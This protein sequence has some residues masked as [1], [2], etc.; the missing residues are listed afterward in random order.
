MVNYFASLDSD[1]EDY[2]PEVEVKKAAPA[3]DVSKT[4]TKSTKS[5]KSNRNGDRNTKKG[6]GGPGP[7]RDG[8][9]QF[10]RRSGTVEVKKSKKVVEDQ[11]TGDQIKM[12]PK[13]QRNY[14]LKMLPLTQ[15]TTTQVMS[16]IQ[17][18]ELL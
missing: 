13:R 8:K 4:T 1:D 11:E 12:K 3:K 10:D 5:M 16:K 14:L 7:A 15:M 2:T 18:M 9:R 17:R 6:R